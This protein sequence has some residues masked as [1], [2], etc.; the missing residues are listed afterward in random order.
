MPSF[1]FNI[2]LSEVVKYTNTLEKMHRS[3]LPVA[4]RGT[5][6]KAAFH[7]KQKTM[8]V[9]AKKHFIHRKP[10]FF[11][12]N[13]K[14]QMAKGFNMKSM[15]SIVGF[16]T[17]NA[18][19][20]HHAVQELQQQEYGGIITN[21][22]FVP[23]QGARV[24]NSDQ[25][26]VQ[27]G[28]RL[29]SIKKIYNVKN[30]NGRNRKQQFIKTA[31]HAG[32]GGFVMGGVSKQMLFKIESIRKIEGRTVINKK[33]LYSYDSGRSVEIEETGFFR[34]A[35]LNSAKLLPQFFQEEAQRQFSRLKR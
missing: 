9:S 34:E 10:N 15:K 20:N 33:A 13:S 25:K 23:L 19:Y 18:G 21:R 24:G 26:Q 35:S 12:A 8:P 11:R 29:S 3:A 2:N 7:V 32:A 28:S 27:S 31:V 6:N 30:A 4:A 16:T 22:S 1:T 5:I 14:V 17:A